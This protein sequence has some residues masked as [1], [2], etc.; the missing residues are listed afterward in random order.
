MSIIIKTQK[1][2]ILSTISND[3]L[4]SGKAIQMEGNWYVDPSL[5]DITY[6]EMEGEGKNYHCPVKR[7]DCDYYNF[8]FEDEEIK[9]IG[10]IYPSPENTQYKQIA[11]K[12]GFWKGRS[13]VAQVR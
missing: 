7:G 9:E 2:V 6:L 13:V 11:G 5:V 3:D 1:G 4:D 10:W 12:F 8:S